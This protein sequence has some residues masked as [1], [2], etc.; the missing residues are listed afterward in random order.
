VQT[1][2]GRVLSPSRSLKSTIIKHKFK[3]NI[4]LNHSL[5]I[6]LIHFHSKL[7]ILMQLHSV[8]QSE[9]SVMYGRKS[10]KSVDT[11]GKKPANTAKSHTQSDRLSHTQPLPLKHRVQQESSAA[12]N[13]PQ[14][15]LPAKS[16]FLQLPSYA[17][18]TV[19][20][21]HKHN[22]SAVNTTVKSSQSGSSSSSGSSGSSGSSSSS[23]SHIPS[24]TAS[25]SSVHLHSTPTP[26]P[27]LINAATTESDSSSSVSKQVSLQDSLA[28][29]LRDATSGSESVGSNT[30]PFVLAE[31]HGS[32]YFNLHKRIEQHD[33]H[34]SVKQQLIKD[35]KKITFDHSADSVAKYTDLIGNV[36]QSKYLLIDETEPTIDISKQLVKQL[37]LKNQK[38][39]DAIQKELIEELKCVSIVGALIHGQ[40]FHFVS[41]SGAHYSPSAQ[42][43]IAYLKD[44]ARQDS[45]MVLLPAISNNFKKIVDL[46]GQLDLEI[47]KYN[48]TKNCAEFSFLATLAKLFYNYG[49]NVFVTGVVNVPVMI[50]DPKTYESDV[51]K[52]SVH[53]R[54]AAWQNGKP[55]NFEGHVIHHWKCC[56]NCQNNK[57][58]YLSILGVMRDLGSKKLT[59]DTELEVSGEPEILTS[60]LHAQLMLLMEEASSHEDH[61]A[62]KSVEV[63][64]REEKQDDF[65]VLSSATSAKSPVSTT[66]PR[67]AKHFDF[68]EACQQQALKMSKISYANSLHTLHASRRPIPVTGPMNDGASSSTSFGFSSKKE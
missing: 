52:V 27:V 49:H 24:M 28:A 59:I 23:S 57:P 5:S 16:R 68:T 37:Q 25:L 9:N 2:V 26:S 41:I 60:P 51:N 39:K 33:L 38:Y 53:A 12:S 63:N 40:Q 4:K 7:N 47:P 45:T 19:S 14:Q 17:A 54:M 20:M 62:T 11:D 43:L 1:L 3:N 44:I 64:G 36:S 8:L 55:W 31:L 22:Q 46:F 10:G 61:T 67:P 42:R 66:I 58:L 65:P 35:H 30:V 15:D 6:S 48:V 50:A 13:Q 21:A 29:T 56:K 34:K 32:P 18:A